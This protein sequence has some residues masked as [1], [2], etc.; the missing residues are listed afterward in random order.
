MTVKADTS[1]GC[2]REG[3]MNPEGVWNGSSRSGMKD[4]GVYSLAG[5]RRKPG[6]VS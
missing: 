1:W 5:I 2:M 4:G 6:A 3:L